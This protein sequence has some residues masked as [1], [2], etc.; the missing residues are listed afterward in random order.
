MMD[1]NINLSFY[2]KYILIYYIIIKGLILT[3]YL[4]KKG[5][6]YEPNITNN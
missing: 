2:W 3:I 6:I 1:N 4:G 5:V